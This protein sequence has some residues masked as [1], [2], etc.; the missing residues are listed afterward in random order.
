MSIG[1][2]VEGT[3]IGVEN[4]FPNL[5]KR[6][7][8]RLRRSNFHRRRRRLNL[9]PLIEFAAYFNVPLMDCYNIYT[10]CLNCTLLCQNSRGP[11]VEY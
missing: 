1:D 2:S 8:G 5:R 6:E 3:S 10:H 7:I 11:M 4:S 9:V